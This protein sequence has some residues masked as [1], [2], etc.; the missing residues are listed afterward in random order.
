V[1]KAE[2]T[3]AMSQNASD[4]SGGKATLVPMPEV[5]STL[6]Q[7]VRVLSDSVNELQN[8][9]GNLVD[10]GALGSS[11]SLY[12]LQCVDAL[13]QNL[14]AI[15]DYL[16]SVSEGSSAEWQIDVARAARSIK[17]EQVRER[18]SGVCREPEEGQPSNAGDFDDFALTG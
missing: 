8:I 14:D 16:K 5:L 4:Q 18:L 13:C 3:E 10:A 1:L 2:G 11:Q 12:E 15:S 6:S 7:E 17:L 9:I